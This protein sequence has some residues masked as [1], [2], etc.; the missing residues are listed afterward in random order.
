MHNKKDRFL[1]QLT[2]NH[3]QFTRSVL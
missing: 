2:S 1:N 3:C